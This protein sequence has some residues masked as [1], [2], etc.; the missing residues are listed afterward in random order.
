MLANCSPADY[1]FEETLST[2]RY[3]SRAKMIKNKPIINEDPKDAMLRQ[4]A[5]EIEQLKKQIKN[6]GIVVSEETP[7]LHNRLKEKE[8]EL[9]LEKNEKANLLKK[10]QELESR[11]IEAKNVKVDAN[12]VENIKRISVLANQTNKKTSI[13]L[14]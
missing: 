7:E 5:I 10:I 13:K 14:D 12:V 1:N 9:E 3:A 2:L 11:H 4:Y 6:G 8:A